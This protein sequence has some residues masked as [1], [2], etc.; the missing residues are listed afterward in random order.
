[1][2][3]LMYDHFYPDFSAGGPI[4]SIANLATLIG[5]DHEVRIITSA[6]EYR[7]GLLIHEIVT[8]KWTVWNAI[9]VWYAEDSKSI[10]RALRSLPMGTVLYLNGLFSVDYFLGPLRQSRKLKMKVVISPRGMLKA[11]ALKIKNFKKR[12]YLSLLLLSGL[13]KGRVWHATDE[14]ELVDIKAKV[15]V[16]SEVHVIPNVPVLPSTASFDKHKTVGEL[17]LIYCSLI[18]GIKNLQFLLRVLN[19]EGMNNISLSIVGPIKDLGYWQKCQQQISTL[20]NP[21]RVKYLGEVKPSNIVETIAGAHVLVL[22]TLGENFGHVIIEALSASRPVLIS[23]NTP[24]RDLN[25]AGVGFSIPLEESVWIKALQQM[26]DWDEN[27]YKMAC[28]AALQYY[29]HKFDFPELKEKYI[30]LFTAV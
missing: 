15:G 30:K 7:S 4:T 24:W 21:E 25:A 3:V 5:N 12:T 6:F 27:N 28:S 22:P 1:M 10:N 13:L 26:L 16:D 11:S 9:P 8:N 14:Q 23:D 18:V 17:Q 29:R 2:T 20:Q 19:A